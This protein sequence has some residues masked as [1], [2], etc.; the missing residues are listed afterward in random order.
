MDATMK[1]KAVIL[2]SGGSDSTLTAGRAAQTGEF[3]EIILMTYEVPVACLDANS[4]RNIPALQKAFPEIRFTHV[5]MPVSRLMHKVITKNKFRSALRHGLVE[6]NLCPLCRLTMYIRTIMYCLDNNIRDVFDGSNITM[7]LWV[8]QTPKGVEM[9]DDFFAAFGITI[10][11]PVFYYALD[12]L[13]DLVRYLSED[14]RK[15]L[16]RKSTSYELH[17][18][19]IVPK[20]DFKADYVESYQAQPV[21]LGVVLSLIYSFGY[22]LTYQSYD[23]FNRNVLKWYAE[24]LDLHKTLLMEY[25]DKGRESELGKVV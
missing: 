22:K 5:M 10:R 9:V 20:K 24:K 11:H 23:T 15:H 3:D 14:D 7:A 17:E 6:S 4:R 18:M 19:N 12:D 21:C 2:F 16:V 8:E 13:F 1:K 25:R